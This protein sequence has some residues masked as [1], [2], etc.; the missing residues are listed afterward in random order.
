M[1]EKIQFRLPATHEQAVIEALELTGASNVNKLAQMV[2]IDY[3][4]GRKKTADHLT[5]INLKLDE[6]AELNRN[7]IG[8]LNDADFQTMYRILGAIFMLTHGAVPVNIKKRVDD[9]FNA[10]AVTDFMEAKD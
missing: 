8:V 5:E 4:E 7:T 3:L 1:F 6:L 2:F 10:S 9:V